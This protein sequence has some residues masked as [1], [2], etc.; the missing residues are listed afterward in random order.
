SVTTGG[1]TRPSTETTLTAPA[2]GNA[3]EVKYLTQDAAMEDSFVWVY[4]K[5]TDLGNGCDTTIRIKIKINGKVKIVLA[6]PAFI[7]QGDTVKFINNSTVVSGGI[8]FLWN[9]GTGKTGDT[10][11]LVNPVFIYNTPGT[12]KVRLTAWT[13][14]WHYPSRDSLTIV[15]CTKPL[16]GFTRSTACLGTSTQFNSTTTPGNSTLIWDFGDGSTSTQTNPTHTYTAANPFYVK[17]VA[18]YNGCKDSIT[19]KIQ[20]YAQPKASFTVVGGR[21]ETDIFEFSNSSTL[22]TGVL[23]NY[24]DFADGSNSN[25]ENPLHKFAQTG[26]LNVKLRVISDFGCKDSIIRQVKVYTSP[27]VAWTNSEPCSVR[28]TLF[29]NQTPDVSGAV[30]NYRWE[31]GDGGTSAAKSPAHAWSTVGPKNVKLKVS[32]D[33]GC[34]DSLSRAIMVK[35]QPTSGFTTKNVCSGSVAQFENTTT[36]PQGTIS[37]AWNLGDGNLST[38]T[39]VNHIYNVNKTTTYNVLLI[40]TIADGCSDTFIKPITV[41]QL[42]LACGFVAEPDYAYSFYGIKMQPKSLGSGTIGGE[43]GVDYTWVIGS[44]ILNASGS[45]AF[46]NHALNADGNY[47]VNYTAKVVSTGCQCSNSM[48]V[49]MN[50]ADVKT[51]NTTLVQL[52]PNPTTG[53]FQLITPPGSNYIYKC[54][55]GTGKEL[56][57]G[58]TQTSGYTSINLGEYPQGLYMLNVAGKDTG[59]TFKVLLTR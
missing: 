39:D 40:A 45:G 3:G 54:L 28:P 38:Q 35:T 32:L 34:T 41:N 1:R 47:A 25:Q 55:N 8:D 10:S 11:N 37:Y 50:R 52:Y 6:A 18:T 29:S 4:T 5:Y 58:T 16:V 44:D 36:Y 14:P 46:V 21:C 23:S 15:V 48:Q 57:S 19:R 13:N 43:D 31:F 24:W 51:S 49:T 22:S 33:N 53:L 12:Y 2:G 26:T 42:P 27:K 30:A 17:L 20:V 9:F 56:I 7:G 59:K